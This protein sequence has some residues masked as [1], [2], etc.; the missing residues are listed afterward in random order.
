[1]AELET[2]LYNLI[3]HLTNRE[4]IMLLKWVLWRCGLTAKDLE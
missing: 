1:M 3:R 4:R 2:K